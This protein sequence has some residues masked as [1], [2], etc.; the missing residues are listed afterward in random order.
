MYAYCKKKLENVEQYKE[1]NTNKNLNQ[2]NI[3]KQRKN[4]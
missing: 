2:E 4:I 3:E 1:K